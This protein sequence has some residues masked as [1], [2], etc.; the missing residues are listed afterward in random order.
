MPRALHVLE[1]PRGPVVADPQV[2]LHQRDR[3]P[4]VLDHD[5]DR[6]VVQRIG[7]ARPVDR[8]RSR[9]AVGFAAPRARL[10]RTAA[11]RADFRYSTTRCTSASATNAPCTRV[12]RPVPGRA[13]RACRPA[14]AATPRPSGR[15]SCASRPGSTPGTTMRAGMLAL[16]SPVITSTDGRCVARIRCMPAARAFCAMRAISSSTFLPVTII[17]S[18]SSSM[19]TTIIGSGS[20]GSGFVR[21]QRERVRR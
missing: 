12:G 14:R 1:Q 7:L 8:R 19:T 5:L 18:A 20:S 3:G 2:P 13:G 17:R 10:R 11:R 16:M 21:R 6:L 4:P 15:G 9:L